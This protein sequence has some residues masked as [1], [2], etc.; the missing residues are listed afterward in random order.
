M[1]F[2]LYLILTVVSSI[3]LE[4]T[5]AVLFSMPVFDIKET[6]RACRTSKTSKEA[7]PACPYINIMRP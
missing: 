2:F 4:F 6:V 5:L 1:T 7:E 3:I